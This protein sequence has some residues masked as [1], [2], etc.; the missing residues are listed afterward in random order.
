[1]SHQAVQ[2]SRLFTQMGFFILFAI[3]PIF[4]LLRYDLMAGHAYFLTFEW[5]VGIDDFMAGCELLW[6]LTVDF[7]EDRGD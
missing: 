1:M 5:H 2:R 6:R 4:D 7:E 3:T